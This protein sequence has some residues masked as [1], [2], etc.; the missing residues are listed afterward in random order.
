MVNCYMGVLGVGLIEVGSG[1]LIYCN[2]GLLV[3]VGFGI[4]LGVICVGMV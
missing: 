2:I 1:V 3:I 4:V